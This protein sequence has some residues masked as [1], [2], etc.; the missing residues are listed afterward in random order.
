M[1]SQIYETYAGCMTHLYVLFY[2]TVQRRVNPYIKWHTQAEI[3]S[4]VRPRVITKATKELCQ[5]KSIRDLYR[6]HDPLICSVLFY[7]TE[8]RESLHKVAHAS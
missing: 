1:S 6:L 3:E 8:E 7:G 2:F 5:L 4:F